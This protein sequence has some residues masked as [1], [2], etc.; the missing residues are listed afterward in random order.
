LPVYL[1]LG[2]VIGAGTFVLGRAARDSR[3]ARTGF[4]ALSGSWAFLAGIAGLVLAGL[5]A[6]TDHAAAYHNEN[7]FQLNPLPLALLWLL[8]RST[9]NSSRWS[10]GLLAAVVVAGLSLTGLLLKLLAAFSQVNGEIIAL[11]LPIHLGVAAGTWQFLRS[12]GRVRTRR[13]MESP[14]N[15]ELPG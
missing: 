11:A 7:L 12:P 6:V 13:A 10:G 5:W 8:P 4:L 1:G 15:T 2:I 9:G 14:I 3:G